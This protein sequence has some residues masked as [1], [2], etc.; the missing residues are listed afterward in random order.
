MQK[1][2]SSLVLA[3][4]MSFTCTQAHATIWFG[5]TSSD[6]TP[7]IAGLSSGPIALGPDDGHGFMGHMRLAKH[8]VG[9]GAFVM[10][11]NEY[12]LAVKL[13]SQSQTSE[14]FLAKM[15]SAFPERRFM[16][17]SIVDGKVLSSQGTTGCN[18]T[19]V[20]CGMDHVG[21]FI[22]NGGGLVDQNVLL[23]AKHVFEAE[24]PRLSSHQ[25]TCRI[26]DSIATSGG[27][28]KDFQYGVIWTS[29]NS[30][31]TLIKEQL[32]ETELLSKLKAQFCP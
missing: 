25:L 31:E 3:A 4:L 1:L 24:S 11:Q 12:E 18:S 28:I 27:E 29:T 10:S 13:E 6:G 8:F 17:G 19:N 5:F 22:V 30:G 7:V 16:I 14:E 26:L 9:I 15:E 21:T 32:K 23:N 20:Y 2:F